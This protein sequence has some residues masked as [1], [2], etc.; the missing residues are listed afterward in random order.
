MNPSVPILAREAVKDVTI[1]ANICN[2]NG[3]EFIIRKD[4]QVVIC[5]YTWQ[6]AEK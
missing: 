2:N 6:R 1:P 4:N 5:N 3:K